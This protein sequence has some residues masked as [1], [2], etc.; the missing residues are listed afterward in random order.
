MVG[1]CFGSATLLAG[2]G[3]F[4]AFNV[5]LNGASGENAVDEQDD[6]LAIAARE[7]L[8]FEEPLVESEVVDSRCARGSCNA[9]MGIASGYLE[10]FL[11]DMR[12][13]CCCGESR[14]E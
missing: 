3:A 10:W 6:G 9:P 12:E 13:F 14:L 5:A 4:A 1:P 7:L 2:S 11:V 8:G